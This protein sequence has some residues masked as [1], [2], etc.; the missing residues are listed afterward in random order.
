LLRQLDDGNTVIAIVSDHG[1]QFGEHGYGYHGNS[2]YRQVLHVPLILKVPGHA[3][4]RVAEPVST[5]DL[6]ASLIRAAEPG[7]ARAPMPLF[8]ARW[9]RPVLSNFDARGRRALHGG[10]SV[11]RD[12]LHFMR[13]L[14]EP[15]TLFDYR[16][17]PAE[18]SPLPL[19]EHRPTVD[20]LRE[21]L[22]RAA[23]QQ[24]RRVDFDALGYLN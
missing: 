5:T 7:R 6:Y 17:D 23:R 11:V 1:E 2:L 13:T 4:G 20:P 16:A 14:E 18:L 12:H 8:D 19:Q 24:T 22:L 3:P 9:R 10:F 15:E 21:M